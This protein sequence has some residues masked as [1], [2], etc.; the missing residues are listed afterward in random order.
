MKIYE[1]K[2]NSS[3]LETLNLDLGISI[4]LY[5]THATMLRSVCVKY[6]EA[7][8]FTNC[9]SLV[10]VMLVRSRIKNY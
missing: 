5:L 9:P 8:K 10:N 6:L 4:D 7:V 3:S 1:F 2:I